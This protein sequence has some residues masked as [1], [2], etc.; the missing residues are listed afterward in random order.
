MPG[1]VH[2]VLLEVET[3]A[4]RS[5]LL[6]EA[7][8]RMSSLILE[9]D[10]HELEVWKDDITRTI[11][12]SFGKKRTKE[13]TDLLE[14]RLTPKRDGG[15]T[16]AQQPAL[17]SSE[18]D[19]LAE[20]LCD[21]LAELSR[22]HIF[23]WETFYLEWLSTYFDRFFDA[24]TRSTAPRQTATRLRQAVRD[25][26]AEIF[27]KGF[28]HVTSTE[29]SNSQYAITKSLN[30]L[31]RFIELPLEFYTNHL[32]TA[33]QRQHPRLRITTSAFLMGVLEGYC[34]V[35]FRDQGGGQVLPR[36]PRS[37]G[38]S[39]AF[40]TADDLSDLAAEIEAGDFRDGIVNSLLP[41]LEALDGLASRRAIDAVVPVLAEFVWGS[42]RVDLTLEPPEQSTEQRDIEVQCFLDPA[43]VQR[44]LIESA[45]SRGVDL[46]IAPVR[47]DLKRVIDDNARTRNVVTITSADARENIRNRITAHLEDAYYEL[48]SPRSSSR[49]IALNYARNFPLD[50]PFRA[51]SSHYY[52][53]RSSVRELLRTL[54]RR[55]GIRLWCS[56]RRSG[57]TTACRSLASSLLEATVVTQTCIRTGDVEER[58]A[59][60]EAISAAL[61]DGRQLP[62]TFLRDQVARASVDAGMRSERFVFVL[63]EY[64]GHVGRSG[65][66][67]PV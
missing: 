15:E 22:A 41:F 20:G 66:T 28:H 53:F 43:F 35:N 42:R 11:A 58:T 9:I 14:R 36:Y 38:H 12:S 59:I 19:Q 33:P 48:R 44:Q 60:F 52:V 1:E 26:S 50:S 7:Q 62:D 5:D 30:G 25:H 64:E 34:R 16:V 21:S 39:M 31:Q 2:D 46:V 63:D 23:Q 45:V 47:P 56:I 18:L 55:N 61:E 13:L 65:V 27:A 54:E 57:K 49:P 3:L 37:W 29:R 4:R 17:D 6:N 51:Q 40:L 67:V 32:N 8:D 10:D 24:V